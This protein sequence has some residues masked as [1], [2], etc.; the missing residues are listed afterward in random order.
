MP[1]VGV[2]NESIQTALDEMHKRYQTIDRY[3]PQGLGLDAATIGRV[4]FCGTS[5]ALRC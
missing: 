3:F 5:T 4:S 1:V 2:Q